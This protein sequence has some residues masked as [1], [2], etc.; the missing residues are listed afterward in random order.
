MRPEYFDWKFEDVRL[1]YLV[2]VYGEWLPTTS[3]M[4]QNEEVSK[5]TDGKYHTRL[6]I[7]FYLNWLKVYEWVLLIV[8]SF[9]TNKI[10]FWEFRKENP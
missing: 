4:N 5:L 10:Q 7:P 2:I 6:D 8:V 3:N 9:Y 1:F